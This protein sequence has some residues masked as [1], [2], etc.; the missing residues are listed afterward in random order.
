MTSTHESSIQTYAPLI[1][2]VLLAAIFLWAGFGKIGGFEGIAGRI[3]SKGVP[4][5]QIVTLIVIALEIGAGLLLLSGFK[6]RWAAVALAAFCVLTALVFHPYWSFPPDQAYN[7]QVHF[8][9]NLALTGGLLFVFAFGPGA[10][11]V[12]KR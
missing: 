12:D 2:R 5:A 4:M 10:L 6:A 9:K 3:A 8:M 7:Q 11:A 1:G